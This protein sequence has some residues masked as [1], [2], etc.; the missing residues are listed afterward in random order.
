MT[1]EKLEPVSVS[2]P[3]REL[4]LLC[5]LVETATDSYTVPLGTMHP[6][7]PRASING[8][9]PAVG[10][11]GVVL[12]DTQAI[13]PPP[14]VLARLQRHWQTSAFRTASRAV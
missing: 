12:R 6:V 14:E 10:S 2:T 11:P 4:R 5:L 8:R 13:A 9:W 1:N 3:R 7:P